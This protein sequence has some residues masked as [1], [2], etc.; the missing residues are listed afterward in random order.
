MVDELLKQLLESGVH[1]GHQTRRWNPKMRKFIFGQR[2]SIHII[3]LEKTIEYLNQARD[4]MRDLAAKG[5]KVLFIGTKKQAQM[6]ISAEAQRCGMFYV[7]NRWPGGLLTNFETVKS[8]LNKLRNIEKM[9]TDGTWENLKKKEIASLETEMAK[10]NKDLGGI[11]EMT[12]CPNAVFIVD[13][14]KESIAVK[15]AR[16]LHVPIVAILDT[17]CDPDVIDY[18]I[19][20]NDDALKSVK[21]LTSLI[22]DSFLEGRRE[23]FTK[24]AEKKKETEGPATPAPEAEAQ[25]S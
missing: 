12:G 1:F 19:P 11:R 3:D 24:E 23:Y 8:S 5:G 9:K 15:E 21:L 16:K 10:I 13:P 7:I 6:T 2:N 22:A 18:P 17:N 25:Q 4:F 20:G 14:H